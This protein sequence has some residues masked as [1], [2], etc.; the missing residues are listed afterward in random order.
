MQNIVLHSNVST[1][2]SI[3]DLE[4]NIFSPLQIDKAIEL[5]E[6]YKDLP[7][8][9]YCVHSIGIDPGFSSSM[10]LQL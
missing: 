3:L 4:G 2:F 10:Q 6:I 9:P 7:I 1:S 5:G 8:N